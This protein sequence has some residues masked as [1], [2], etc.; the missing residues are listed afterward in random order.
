MIPLDEVQARVV[1]GCPPLPATAVPLAAALGRVLAEAVTAAGDVPP[2][3]NSAMDGYAVRAADTTAARPDAPARLRVV[4]TVAAGAVADRPVGPGEALRIM[5][6]APFPDGADAVAVVEVTTADGDDVLVAQ[7]AA[8]GDHVRPAGE[9]LVAGTEVF[10]AGTPLAPG[11]L[12]VLASAGRAE[13]RVVRAPVVGVLSTGDE[14]V[15]PG[16]P[17]G[18]GQ[19]RDSNRLTLLG[20]LR[21]DGFEAVDLGIA[22]DDEADIRRRLHTAAERC[23]A[24]LTSGGVSMGAFDYVRKVLEEVAEMAWVQVAIR[25]AKPFAFGHLGTTPV[26][27]LPGNPV[28]SMVSY[29]VLARPA[30][31][32]MAGFPDGLLHRPVVPA[33]A[34]D[35]SLRRRD[36]G[37]VNFVRVVAQ[38]GADGRH[39]VRSAG[40]QGS[41]LLWPMALADALAVVPSG[42]GV[43]AGGD[44]GVLLLGP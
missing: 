37:R 33:V 29:E 30:L 8:A 28:S 40:G 38:V 14:L 31:R 25:P 20:L 24:V 42:P 9:D 17:L 13:V 43:A 12:G 44:T 16:A 26:F 41:N 5:T 2:F 19:I 22:R 27:G 36:D 35:D 6:G 10:P 23:D 32:R 18:P 11:H 1:A 3:A 39:H 34:D 15:E 7:P 4:G 21:R